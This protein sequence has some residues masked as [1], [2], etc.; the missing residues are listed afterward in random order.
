MS[1]ADFSQLVPVY[2]LVLVRIG[3]MMMYAPLLGSAQ[4]PRQVRALIACVLSLAV[5]RGVAPP[6]EPIRSL[7]LLAVGIG[8]EMVFGLAMG[9]ILSFCFIAAQWA[10][11]LIGQQIGINLSET[12]DP[13]YGTQ[14]AILGNLFFMLTLVVFLTINGHRAM[15][16]G[17]R[18]SFDSLPLLS[19]G[20]NRSLLGLLVGLFEASTQLALQLAAPVLVSLLV[21][22]LALGFIGKTMPQ[23]NVMSLGLSI[24]AIVGMIVLIIG[25]G[26]TSRVIRESVRDGMNSM[27]QAYTAPAPAPSAN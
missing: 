13:Q 16:M 22:D 21:V 5:A 27:Y 9:M 19:V 8:G 2:V 20:M 24:R 4:I 23:L 17:V 10:G 14:G 7:G 1:L 3:A 12:F 18:A 25:I 26:L 6:A 11:D 15:L